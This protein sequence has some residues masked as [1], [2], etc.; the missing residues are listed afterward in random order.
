MS[1]EQKLTIG[2]V[3]ERELLAG[4]TNEEVLDAIKREFPDAS[5]SMAS[6]NWYRNRMRAEGYDVKTSRELRKEAKAKALG[7]EPSPKKA[8]R[9][10]TVKKRSSSKKH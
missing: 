2:R 1:E 9:G 10:V 4:K 7:E 3:A 8:H 5:T 6:V